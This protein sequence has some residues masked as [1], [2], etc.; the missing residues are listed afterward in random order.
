M[1]YFLLILAIVSLVLANRG[2]QITIWNPL[3][4]SP[5]GSYYPSFRP[6]NIFAGIYNSTT[7]I[8]LRRDHLFTPASSQDDEYQNPPHCIWGHDMYCNGKF[9]NYTLDGGQKYWGYDEFSSG[10]NNYADGYGYGYGYDYYD[11][12]WFDIPA[13]LRRVHPQHHKPT[14]TSALNIPTYFQNG[15]NRE[16]YVKLAHF[17]QNLDNQVPLAA[18]TCYTVYLDIRSASGNLVVGLVTRNMLN[19][20]DHGF[21]HPLDGSEYNDEYIAFYRNES[22]ETSAGGFVNGFLLNGDLP[23]GGTFSQTT[24]QCSQQT[25]T[26]PTDFVVKIEICNQTTIY[27]QETYP[28]GNSSK[29][30][31]YPTSQVYDIDLRGNGSQ[32]VSLDVLLLGDGSSN[33]F[34]VTA[35]VVPVIYAQG[36][37]RL[38]YSSVLD[39]T[40]LNPANFDPNLVNVSS[41]ASYANSSL[42]FTSNIFYDESNEPDALDEPNELLCFDLNQ[43]N[44]N[45][46]KDY[47]IDVGVFAQAIPPE[48][49]ENKSL[50]VGIR[51]GDTFVGFN[52]LGY[53]FDS[54]GNVITATVTDYYL[55]NVTRLDDILQN[56]PSNGIVQNSNLTAPHFNVKFLIYANSGVSIYAGTPDSPP[57]TFVWAS[58]GVSINFTDSPS[59]CLYHQV[60]SIQ[61]DWGTTPSAQWKNITTVLY[62]LTISVENAQFGCDGQDLSGAVVDSCGVCGGKNECVGCDGIPF[63]GAVLDACGQCQGTNSTCCVNRFGISDAHWDWLLLPHIIEDVSHRLKSLSGQLTTTCSLLDSFSNLCNPVDPNLLAAFDSIDLDKHNSE[64]VEFENT[65]LFNFSRTITEMIRDISVWVPLNEYGKNLLKKNY[66]NL[67][68]YI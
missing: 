45:N 19:K 18:D 42:I 4:T 57:Y 12:A 40:E 64:L 31:F 25:C 44:L 67:L 2:R 17:W 7:G 65:C 34:V 49:S 62:G 22:V 50:A 54:L 37:D 63:S 55:V 36:S 53:Y 61:D 11:G 51:F 43:F 21:G 41:I 5:V 47:I 13:K 32:P 10:A 56:R 38:I 46:G 33:V 3:E 30:N 35:Q 23:V 68:S 39:G 6:Q 8:A 58:S 27:F 24:L 29:N 52:R 66:I 1:K 48:T 26:L 28:L 60:E 59:L 14:Y 20:H 15:E 9:F 16:L